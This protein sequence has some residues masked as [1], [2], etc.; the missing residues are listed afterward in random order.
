MSQ[1]AVAS[2]AA[3]RGARRKWLLALGIA[4]LLLGAAGAGATTLLDLTFSLVFGPLLIAGGVIQIFVAFVAEKGKEVVLHLVAAALEIVFGLLVMAD[5]VRA[6]VSVTVLVAI[7]LL[8]AAGVRLARALVTPS[9]GRGWFAMAGAA[10]LLLAVCVYVEWPGPKLWFVG[11]C[12]AIDFLC[13]G[14]SWAALALAENKPLAPG[15]S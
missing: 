4:L 2:G 6:A 5:P 3:D 15:A 10:A 9:A 8:L 7:F 14:A 11:L 1:T 13:H 12:L